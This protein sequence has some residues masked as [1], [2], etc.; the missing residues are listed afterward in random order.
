MHC[1]LPLHKFDILFLKNTRT[2]LLQKADNVSLWYCQFMRMSIQEKKT[3]FI[4]DELRAIVHLMFSLA[5]Y[6]LQLCAY[7][8][9][10]AI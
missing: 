3:L 9:A 5:K 7:F 4:A 2:R 6:L 8:A 10:A 1:H